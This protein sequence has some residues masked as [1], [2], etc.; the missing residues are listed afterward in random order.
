MVIKLTGFFF[1]YSVNNLTL[2]EFSQ[3]MISD[4]QYWSFLHTIILR[5][6]KYWQ[7]IY[8]DC[9]DA[10][11][12]IVFKNYLMLM[13]S[14]LTISCRKGIR[15]FSHDSPQIIIIFFQIIWKSTYEIVW[16][17]GENHDP[18]YLSFKI[19]Q[20]CFDISLDWQKYC[21]IKETFYM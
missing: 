21:K 8:I 2:S 11:L 17:V 13:K 10:P 9:L 6:L 20:F 5:T 16:N 1:G 7:Y 14:A 18:Q 19:E 15:K 3:G 4:D 12:C